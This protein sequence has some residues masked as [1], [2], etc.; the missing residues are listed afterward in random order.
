MDYRDSGVDIDAG[1]E[2]VRRIKSLAKATFTPGVLSDIGSFGGLFQLDRDRYREPGA[3]VERRRRRH[4]A[5]G[6]VHD[7]PARHRGR[8]PREPLRERHPRPGRASRCSSST[9]SRR[10]GCRPRS[11]SRSS[12]ASRADAARTGARCSAERPPRCPVSTPTASTTSRASSS[13]WSI[14]RSVIDGRSICAG[15]C[16]DRPAVRRP[17]HQRLL[18]RA[19][20]R[21]SSGSA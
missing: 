21:C 16:P 5:Q 7:G 19:A 12:P 15:R 3:R 11:P 20:D 9:T 2:T 6:G 13:A 1:N 14:E 17:A 18:A 8:R 10:D 4:Q